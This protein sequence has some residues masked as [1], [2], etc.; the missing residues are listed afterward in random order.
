[1]VIEVIGSIIASSACTSALNQY[2]GGMRSLPGRAGVQESYIALMQYF[3]SSD[4]QFV[5]MPL[6]ALSGMKGKTAYDAI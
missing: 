2:N 5:I 4:P 6:I 1:M 3:Q